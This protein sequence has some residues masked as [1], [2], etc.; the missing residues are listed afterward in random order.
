LSR[1]KEE[2]DNAYSMLEDK[3]YKVGGVSYKELK[4]SSGKAEDI[5]H[6]LLDTKDKVDSKLKYMIKTIYKELGVR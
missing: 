2:F 1:L 6:G 3:L 4:G 5:L